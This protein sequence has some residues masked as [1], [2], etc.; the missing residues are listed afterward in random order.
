[1]SENAIIQA[2]G[3]GLQLATMDDY[4]DFAITVAKSGLAPR[5]LDTPE[6]VVVAVQMGAEIGFTPMQSLQSIAVINGTATI[7]GDAA[8]ALVRSS[9]LLEWIKEDIEGSFSTDLAKVSGAVEAV[10]TV[11]RK[12]DPEP[13]TRKFC[14]AEARLARLWGKSGPWS[15]HPQRMLKYKARA[16]ALRDVFPDVLKGLHVGEELIGEP[17]IRVESNEIPTS[18][19]LLEDDNGLR[20][21][22]Q[23]DEPV[24]QRQAAGGQAGPG[25]HGTGESPGRGGMGEGVDQRDEGRDAEIPQGQSRPEAAPPER[26]AGDEQSGGGGV[27]GVEEWC[28]YCPACDFG[29][30]FEKGKTTKK[31]KGRTVPICPKCKTVDIQAWEDHVNQILDEAALA[32]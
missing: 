26:A 18:Q 7:Y 8:L 19:Q 11:K 25:L 12:G 28:Y 3:R 20:T 21:E 1:M 4:K 23:R 6:K 30:D 29:F 13:V 22:K 5:S 2:N 24:S 27:S 9:G 16:F 17:P 15:S 31:I 32:D 14:V 10:C